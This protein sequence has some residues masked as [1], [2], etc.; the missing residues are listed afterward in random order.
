MCREAKA[1][2][3][4]GWLLASGWLVVSPMLQE[5][6]GLYRSMLFFFRDVL[7]VGL[8][9]IQMDTHT[10]SQILFLRGLKERVRVF[11]GVV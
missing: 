2:V 8:R 4:T 1:I 3:L 6:S 10:L 5:E 7:L 11:C 9:D